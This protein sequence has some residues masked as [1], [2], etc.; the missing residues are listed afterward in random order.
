MPHAFSGQKVFVYLRL[1]NDPALNTSFVFYP[2][3][4]PGT[5]CRTREE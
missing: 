4:P 5:L 3:L 1:M 2:L